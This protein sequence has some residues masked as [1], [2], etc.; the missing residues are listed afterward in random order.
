VVASHHAEM[1]RR[2]R[3]L[4][5]FDVLY[6]SPKNTHGHL[7]FFFA[8]DRARVTPNTTI[9]INDKTVSHL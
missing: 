3:E 1:P 5:L 6:P 4:A 9:L 8:R 2:M 7:V